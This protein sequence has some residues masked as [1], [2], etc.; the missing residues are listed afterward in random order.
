MVFTMLSVV[1]VARS[2]KVP[3]MQ[4]LC[5]VVWG[6]PNLFQIWLQQLMKVVLVSEHGLEG[7]EKVNSRSLSSSL[8][9]ERWE[10]RWEM[11]LT[12]PFCLRRITFSSL[13]LIFIQG[14]KRVWAFQL[15]KEHMKCVLEGLALVERSEDEEERS[16]LS[17]HWAQKATR[18]HTRMATSLTSAKVHLSG[19]SG[20]FSCQKCSSFHF[21]SELLY[22]HNY[23][24]NIQNF[25]FIR[26][27]T[28]SPQFCDFQRFI[29]M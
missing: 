15:I 22:N 2:S 23:I 21:F 19:V 14:R 25:W 10:R 7:V 28:L 13:W 17:Q 8:L 26:P 4:K 20:R 11:R 1:P 3:P 9:A 16:S 27:S 24:I 12:E 6:Y 29:D 5:P 18:V